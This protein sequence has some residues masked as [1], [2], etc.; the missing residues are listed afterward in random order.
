[1]KL[2]NAL[3]ERSELQKRIEQ[4]GHRL[5]I[6]SRVQEGEKPA[7]DPAELTEE[8]DRC[9]LRLEKLI[10]AINRI[11]NTPDKEG[12]SLS[13]LLAKRECLMSRLRIMREFL[14]E[15]SMLT[16]RRAASEIKTY[17]TVNVRELQKQL[18]LYAR[19]LR[20]TDEKIQ[21]RNWTTEIDI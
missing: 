15:A 2:A 11:N 13:D 3:S 16:Q 7:E 1:M 8:L 6:N 9:Y 18:D 14:S 5:N 19:E 17:S 20:E 12:I 21:E 10:A 4:L